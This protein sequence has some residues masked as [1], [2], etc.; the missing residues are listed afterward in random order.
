L[1]CVPDMC[2][3]TLWAHSTLCAVTVPPALGPVR[4]SVVVPKGRWCCQIFQ[5]PQRNWLLSFTVDIILICNIIVD[6]S[7][8]D[9]EY[10]CYS[11]PSV[12]ICKQ[13]LPPMMMVSLLPPAMLLLLLSHAPRCESG[14][15]EICGAGRNHVL[16]IYF[17]EAL[18]HHAAEWVWLPHRDSSHFLHQLVTPIIVTLATGRLRQLLQRFLAPAQR[19][20]MMAL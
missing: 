17:A 16:S 2:N 14:S 7:L 6:S 5:Q 3:P 4:A 15:C 8:Y 19:R 18:Y 13:Q 20:R 12:V 1:T 10:I 11:C 9:Y